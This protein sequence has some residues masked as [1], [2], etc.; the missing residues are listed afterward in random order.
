[1]AQA[2]LTSVLVCTVA[3]PIWASRIPGPHRAL[4]RALT[5]FAVCCAAY[6][7]AVIEIYRFA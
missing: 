7:V 3:V 1:M 6:L 5:T 2:I 4:R